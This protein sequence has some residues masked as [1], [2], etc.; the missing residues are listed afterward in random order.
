M[1]LVFMFFVT[2]YHA[3]WDHLFLSLHWCIG[4]S[5]YYFSWPVSSFVLCTSG[6]V[7]EYFTWNCLHNFSQICIDSFAWK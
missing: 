2:F 6:N 4:I 3:F 1:C 7:C 5:F